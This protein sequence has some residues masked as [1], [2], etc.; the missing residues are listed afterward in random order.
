MQAQVQPA[1][2]GVNGRVGRRDR[3][4]A[5][6]A[7]RHGEPG[8]T[9][10][11]GQHLTPAQGV[12]QV[13][14]PVGLA[15]MAFM[16]RA[17]VV[18]ARTQRCAQ[19]AAADEAA[20]GRGDRLAKARHQHRHGTGQRLGLGHLEQA[21]QFVEQGSLLQRRLVQHEHIAA[22]RIG[23]ARQLVEAADEAGHKLQIRIGKRGQAGPQRLLYVALREAKKAQRQARAVPVLREGQEIQRGGGDSHDGSR[24]KTTR[25]AAATSGLAPAT[26]SSGA[27][28]KFCSNWVRKSNR[29]FKKMAT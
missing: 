5:E 19:L 10:G 16:Q 28:G 11:E 18:V 1:S 3:R 23:L 7:Q 4:L 14:A 15:G 8:L 29:S 17:V 22:Q 12:R 6:Q 25:V 26:I 27:R 20:V 21:G 13:D 2:T 9:Q 24:Y